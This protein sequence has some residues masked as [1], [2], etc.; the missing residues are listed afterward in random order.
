MNKKEL[1]EEIKR[2]KENEHRTRKDVQAVMAKLDEYKDN[3][4]IRN[5]LIKTDFVG[6]IK[7][8]KLIEVLKQSPLDKV[9]NFRDNFYSPAFNLKKRKSALEELNNVAES[10]GNLFYNLKNDSLYDN[11]KEEILSFEFANIKNFYERVVELE[12]LEKFLDKYRPI[13]ITQDNSTEDSI[14]E[15]EEENKKSDKK[16]E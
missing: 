12:L 10:I 5:W 2:L 7:D 8:E 3:L 15:V 16:G 14:E 11:I 1:I 13:N 6:N 9:E 4:R